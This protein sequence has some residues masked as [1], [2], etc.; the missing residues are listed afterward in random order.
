MKVTF[1]NTYYF[2]GFRKHGGTGASNCFVYNTSNGEM[3]Y[4]TTFSDDGC[5]ISPSLTV[6]KDEEYGL[7][8]YNYPGSSN[9]RY[10]NQNNDFP[11]PDPP[12]LTWGKGYYS[13]DP[14]TQTGF[15]MD[16]EIGSGRGADIVAVNISDVPT[17]PPNIDD[18]TWNLTSDGGCTNWRT[19]K[20]NPCYTTDTTPT[21]KFSTDINADC[22]FC[23]SDLNYSDCVNADRNGTTTGGTSHVVTVPV[24]DALSAKEQNIYMSCRSLVGEENLTSTSGALSVFIDNKNPQ[25]FTELK[26]NASNPSNGSTVMWEVEF[27]DWSNLSTISFYSN[28]T[29]D[30]T[31]YDVSAN[32]NRTYFYYNETLEN[33]TANFVYCVSAYVNDTFGQENRS[34]DSCY[35]VTGCGIPDSGS[36]TLTQ[37]CS[38]TTNQ[39][40]LS[41]TINIIDG[42]NIYLTGGAFI[43]ADKFYI[44]DGSYL[45]VEDGSYVYTE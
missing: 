27:G 45:Y 24:A 32:G 18:S 11:M 44:E 34:M 14:P 10:D 20:Q 38:Y 16:G 43:A 31:T 36:F 40:K 42:Y 12:Y 35:T 17:Y 7:Y 30:N 5:F 22:G 3:L 25:V 2:E 15:S 23:P 19:D 8:L 37:D 39:S 13:S 21:I 4:N 26:N 33:V 28:R 41:T 9:K 1:N 29:G 6:H